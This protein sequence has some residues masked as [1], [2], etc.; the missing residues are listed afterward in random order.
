MKSYRFIFLP[1]ISVALVLVY[2]VTRRKPIDWGIKN[3][4]HHATRQSFLFSKAI[5]VAVA[6]LQEKQSDKP[7][8]IY[9][10]KKIG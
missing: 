10:Q 5:Q 9:L 2:Y 8:D 3:R 4:H 7:L 6:D 1:L